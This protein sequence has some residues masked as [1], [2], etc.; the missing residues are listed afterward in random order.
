MGSKKNQVQDNRIL[1]I[2]LKNQ[3]IGA[4]G[5][6][7]EL[8]P[9]Y[10]SNGWKF[11]VTDILEPNGST[12]SPGCFFSLKQADILLPL[13]EKDGFDIT[14]LTELVN[15]MKKHADELWKR[16]E[17]EKNNQKKEADKWSSTIEF[18]H[19]KNDIF[20]VYG[21]ETIII[22]VLEKLSLPKEKKSLASV[23]KTVPGCTFGYKLSYRQIFSFLDELEGRWKVNN[24]R[25]W[26]MGLA[27]E[28]INSEQEASKDLNTIQDINAFFEWCDKNQSILYAGTLNQKYYNLIGSWRFKHFVNK[29]TKFFSQA[30]HLDANCKEWYKL[31]SSR[32]ERDIDSVN[33]KVPRARIIYTPMGGQIKRK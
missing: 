30:K 19:S 14:G 16:K 4:Y 22:E 3:I 25:E 12:V 10:L 18:W 1:F 6:Y 23:G 32:F 7:T 26:A 28:I 2:K 21:N 27:W 29:L 17:E 15:G 24:V 11:K 31:H 13:M 33:P 20:L 5:D 8:K 9:Y